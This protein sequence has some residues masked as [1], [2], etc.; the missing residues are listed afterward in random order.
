M[1]LLPFLIVT[2]GGAVAVL[3]VRGGERL[4]TAIGMLALLVASLAALAIIPDEVV[5]LGG[6]G[7]V[8]TAYA[9]LFLALG[10]VVGLGSAVIGAAAG[11]RRDATAVTLAVLGTSAVALAL[12]DPRMAVLAATA[13]GVFG[14]LLCITPL[15]GR[16]GTAVGARAVRA[17]II[18][19]VLAIAATAWIGR[20]LSELV[21]QPVVFGLAYLAMAVAVA[22][23]FGAIP[24]HAWAARLTDAVPES[25][26]PL[27]T[28]WGPAALAV[29]ALAWVDGS[30]AP[31]LVDV[32]PARAVVIAVAL[33]TLVLAWVAAW[34][35][36]DLE[37]IVGYAIIGDAAIILLA[38]AAL[39][40]DVWAP[41]RTWI[42]A[43]VVSRSAFAGWAAAIRATYFTGRLQDLRGW[44]IRSPLLGIALIL[45]V[46]AS[47][48]LPGLAAFEA[49]GTV[50]GL[51]LDGPLAAVAWVGALA[52]LAYYA[53][54]LVVGLQRPDPGRHGV[55]L[56]PRLQPIALTDL[57]RWAAML[58]A[59]NRAWVASASA[60][61]LAVVAL[62]VAVGFGGVPQAA[63]GLPP[64]LD[65]VS[66]P[67]QPGPATPTPG[68]TEAPTG[69]PP[70]TEEPSFQPV[71]TPP[72]SSPPASALP[73]SSAPA[74]PAGASAAPSGS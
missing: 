65:G 6:S 55:L 53:R 71:P 40:P 44:A 49:R 67:Q 52:P 13:G 19:G 58:W 60:T 74:S 20:D 24:V 16:V 14:A 21:A 56:R 61:G 22:I 9:R 28:A 66:G 18:A 63:A 2:V 26:L 7:L 1:T 35:Q 47:I 43:F 29:V 25:S 69:A 62:L 37:H 51:V 59:D 5:E 72:A 54:L 64:S 17:T 39:D 57:R 36:D 15:G 27:I 12:P 3:F 31:L 4:A 73:A 32:E 41:A 33:L 23:R 30:I 48:G 8:T 38:V 11:S 34:I 10:A 46:L 68:P 70:A 50:I 42:L 45:V